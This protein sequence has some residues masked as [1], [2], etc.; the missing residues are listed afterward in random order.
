MHFQ[1]FAQLGNTTVSSPYVE[2]KTVGRKVSRFSL[3]RL[4]VRKKD[5]QNKD[6]VREVRETLEANE[7]ENK[8]SS[9]H[10]NVCIINYSRKL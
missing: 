4:H 7:F 2:N 3:R 9:E 8:A 6:E 10:T 1:F 5:T